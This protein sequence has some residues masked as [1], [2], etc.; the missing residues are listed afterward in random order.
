M[1]AN[2]QSRYKKI[3][4]DR[5][6]VQE[7]FVKVFLQSRSAPPERIVLDLDATD[8]PLHGHRQTSRPRR[9]GPAGRFFHGYYGNYCYLPLY[10]FCGDDLLCAKLRPSN[11]DASAGALKEVQRLVAAIREKW[12][13]VEIT[14]RGDS[15]FCREPIMTGPSLF[16]RLV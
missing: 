4:L 3:T 8:D 16:G 15:G 6:A 5:K 9:E 13:H 7:L 12:P 11:I 14:I 1:R 2:A 10:I